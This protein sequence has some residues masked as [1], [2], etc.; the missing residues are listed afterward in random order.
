M[1]IQSRNQT[2]VERKSS[3]PWPRARSLNLSARSETDRVP[4]ATSTKKRDPVAARCMKFNVDRPDVGWGGCAA[5]SRG[6]SRSIGRDFEERRRLRRDSSVV[7]RSS[8]AWN[9]CLEFLRDRR[10]CTAAPRTWQVQPRRP[11]GPFF[12]PSPFPARFFVLFY[13]PPPVFVSRPLERLPAADR[14]PTLADWLRT[15]S[16]YRV[17]ELSISVRWEFRARYNLGGRGMHRLW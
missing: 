8:A 6:I 15:E 2:R 12:L 7:R 16:R 14:G 10:P 5:D 11:V 4:R 17:R 3:Y 9:R 13:R 1:R